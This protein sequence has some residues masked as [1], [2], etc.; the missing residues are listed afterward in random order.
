[1]RAVD[2]LR[3]YLDTLFG[4]AAVGQ[5]IEVR[6]R[7]ADGRMAPEFFPVAARELAAARIER[8]GRHA[9]VYVGCAPRTRR[10]GR[11]ESVGPVGALWA[12]CDDAAA[13][14]RARAWE[15]APTMIVRSGTTGARHFYW[16]LYAPLPPPRAELANLRLAK[17]I[18]AD[19]C[20]DA[21]RILRPP[22]TWN[23]KHQP[24]REVTLEQHAH[25]RTV[26]VA[27]VLA[28]A[29]EIDADVVE[30][31]WSRQPRDPGDDRLLSIAPPEYVRVLLGVSPGRDGKVGCPFHSDERPSLHV[32]ASAA[33]GWSC[34][35]CGRGGSIYD[36]AAGLWELETRGRDFLRVR[37]RLLDA[38][39]RD[40]GRSL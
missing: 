33:R 3:A 1:L 2:E 8:H 31:S 14:E 23:F 12:D 22:G 35:S 36:L 5:W 27:D 11:K 19:R 13:S 15:P 26:R 16:R 39:N 7:L 10:S 30:R 9:D 28:A 25:S 4:H 38:F 32:Y 29:V 17:S 24:P 21:G 6:C 40:L 34:F 18:G 37:R 20:H